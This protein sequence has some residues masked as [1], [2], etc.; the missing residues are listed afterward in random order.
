[1]NT[2]AP[3]FAKYIVV[4]L[5]GEEQA[6][7]FPTSK[8]HAAVARELGLPVVSAGF[9]MDSD[10]VGG[11]SESLKVESRKQDLGLLC[12]MLHSSAR[13][14]FDRIPEL[15]PQTFNLDEAEPTAPAISFP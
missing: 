2:S 13:E 10:W 8:Q 6:V 4:L 3:V 11:E 7:R 12:A 1:M 9:C 5:D 14:T 15:E